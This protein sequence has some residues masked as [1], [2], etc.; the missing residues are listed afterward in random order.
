M[1]NSTLLKIAL[2]GILIV[3]LLFKVSIFE[4]TST[5][6]SLNLFYLA[7]AAILVPVLLVLRTLRW[8]QYLIINEIN[9]PFLEAF[10]VLLIGNFYGLIT[11]GHLGEIGRA[12]HL[13][14]KKT[15]TLPTIILE[16]SVDICTLI[17]L[18]S[19]TIFLVFPENTVLIYLIL[20]CCIAA[21]LGFF[22]L[23]KKELLIPLTGLAGIDKNDC[24]LFSDA[25]WSMVN[26]YSLIS[27]SFLIS[28]IYYAIAYLISYIVA[29]A[30]GFN[31]LVCITLPI[32]V[33][34]G[35]IPLTIAGL[36]LRE[37]V[38]SILF[39][40]LGESAAD[41]IVFAF[42]LFIL[43]SVMPAFLGYILA[44]MG[45]ENR[46]RCVGQMNGLFSPYLEARRISE[47]RKIVTGGMILDYG[48]GNG[49]LV[50]SIPFN[51]YTG[52]DLDRDVI[53]EA[54]RTFASIE[55]ASFY[56]IE[57][58]EE[59]HEVYDVIILSAVIEHFKDPM[60]TLNKLTKQLK[61]QGIIIITTPSLR[62]NDLLKI[63]SMA[64]IFSRSAY[65]EHNIIFA[66]QDFFEISEKLGLTVKKYYT[67]EF[68]LNQFVILSRN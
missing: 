29:I 60:I 54:R 4:I 31:P 65:E 17:V 50:S 44:M 41:G 12:F 48:C 67:F 66:K 49:R 21:P 55:N 37:S 64:G 62:G 61:E 32:I 22:L 39:M 28:L 35:N 36:G 7:F 5:M 1:K 56:F 42:V 46:V 9:I 15:I 40:Y 24:E 68:G 25:I 16:K 2:T 63:G 20:I 33:L 43:I 58:F 45:E 14:E 13:E 8:N 26:N 59:I 18:S 6:L 23:T 11:P 30:A 27:L 57:E 47:I 53:L 19:L 10:R 38:G 3:L 34:M 51:R 52:T